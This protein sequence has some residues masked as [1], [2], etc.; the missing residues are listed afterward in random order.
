M[1]SALLTLPDTYES[2]THHVHPEDIESE[3]RALG[4]SPDILKTTVIR[5][6]YDQM[7]S[8]FGHAVLRSD[9]SR[10]TESNFADFIKNYSLNWFLN[11]TL[12]P[13]KNV[14]GIRFLKFD[15]TNLHNT[16]SALIKLSN[17][18][19][20][21]YDPV[22][23]LSKIGGGTTPSRELLTPRTRRLIEERFPEDI[24]LWQHQH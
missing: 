14:S 9:S 24:E 21:T 3:T 19:N 6:P 8:W 11:D 12:N 13:Y 23:Q 5:N 1:V 4:A 10:H 15:K 16:L 20:G 18:C 17:S 22:V 2:S 7:L